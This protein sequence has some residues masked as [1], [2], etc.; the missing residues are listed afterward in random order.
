MP[1]KKRSKS[2]PPE[3]SAKIRVGPFKA[4][5]HNFKKRP[6]PRDPR[7]DSLSGEFNPTLFRRS[8]GFINEIRMKE[9]EKLKK[10]ISKEKD[11]DEKERLRKALNIL[12][13]KV[14]L[15]KR[16]EQIQ[17]IKSKHRKEQIERIK[18]GKNPYFLSKRKLNELAK[19]N[20]SEKNR[21]KRKRNKKEK[22][23]PFRERRIAN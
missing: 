9:I 8:Y 3:L 7:F 19:S 18:Q 6:E 12:Q 2:E 23:A 1:K 17:Q 22:N 4:K 13:S 11:E 15:E 20:T 14:A 5:I 10:Q 16:E 21:K